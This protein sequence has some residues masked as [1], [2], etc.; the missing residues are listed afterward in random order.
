[1]RACGDLRFSCTFYIYPCYKFYSSL[2]I[3]MA[4][5]F[6]LSARLIVFLRGIRHFRGR[7]MAVRHRTRSA[8][9]HDLDPTFGWVVCDIA[10][11]FCLIMR[12]P[13]RWWG[14]R[15]EKSCH[16]H[17][18][19]HEVRYRRNLVLRKDLHPFSRF[20][21]CGKCDATARENKLVSPS[22]EYR[23]GRH[24]HS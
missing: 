19:T 7:A 13:T 17:F 12:R 15:P 14:C 1:M 22:R 9:W 16:S 10:H 2:V 5:F 21:I 3:R 18:E 11:L 8:E 6:A 24:S 4:R 20:A 23:F